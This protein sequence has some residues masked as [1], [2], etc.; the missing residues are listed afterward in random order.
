[1]PHQTSPISA[2]SMKSPNNLKAKRPIANFHPSIWK[3]H[4]LSLSSEATKIDVEVEEQAKQL[5]GE[6]KKMLIIS[7]RNPFKILNLVDSIQRLNVSYHFENEIDQILEQ[8]YAN[9]REFTNIDGNDDLYTISLLFRLL[10]QQGYKIPCDIFTKF[11]ESNGKFKESLAENARAILSLYE[12]AHMRVHGEDVL[13][14][15]LDFSVKHLK[16][17]ISNSS[18]IFVAEVTS[19]LKYPLRKAIPRMKAREYIPIYEEDPSHSK[20]LLTFSKLDFNILQKLHQKELIEVI[21]WWKD[22]K[23]ETNFSFARDR[24]VECYLWTLGVYFEPQ[25]SV[26]R[27]LLTKVTAISSILDDIYDAYGTFE[28]LQVLTPAIQRWDRSMVNVLPEYMKPFYIAMLD[29]YKEISKEIDKDESSLHVHI[30]KEEIKKLA[31]SYFEEAKW[32]SKNYKPNFKEHMELA[33]YTT[34]YS[35]LISISLLV[36]GNMVT[37]DVLQWVSRRPKIIEGSTIIC[38]LMDDIVSHKFEQEREHVASAVECY[39]EQYGCSEE[40][41]CV[42]LHKQVVDAWKD[43]NEACLHPIAVPMPILMRTV[44]FSRVMNVIYSD[45]DGYTNSNG[46]TKFIIESLLVNSVPC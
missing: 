17:I 45:E 46:K 44:N 5:K 6:V 42:E 12:A 39:I 32:L 28:E 33:L 4:F 15:A 8:I 9:Y 25:F 30:A 37:N 7:N 27:K 16:N 41:A 22:L 24:I 23:V 18:P 21:R 3:D 20:T 38:R 26:G 31:E 34:G 36:M 2:S 40:E 10:R 19:A 1:M 13:E 43:V 14:E 29:L 11:V 35:L